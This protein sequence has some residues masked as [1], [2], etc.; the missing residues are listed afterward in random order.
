MAPV[1]F[2]AVLVALIILPFIILF[3]PVQLVVGALIVSRLT[4]NQVEETDVVAVPASALGERNPLVPTDV[5]RM[6]R[7]QRQR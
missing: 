3:L 1:L 4:R 7:K 2:S 5:D 6:G